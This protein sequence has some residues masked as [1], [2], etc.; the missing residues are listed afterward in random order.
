MSKRKFSYIIFAAL[1]ALMCVFSVVIVSACKKKPDTSGAEAGQYFCY[2]PENSEEYVVTLSKG[3]RFDYSVKGVQKGGKYTLEGDR[4]TLTYDASEGALV[5]KL[6]DNVISLTLD[7]AEL[8]FY[9][10]IDYTVTFE[11][12]GGSAVAPVTVV[13]GKT[14]S[15]PAEDPQKKDFVFVGWYADEGFGTAYA[16]GSAIVTGNLTLYARWAPKVEGQTEYEISFELGYAGAENPASVE[17]VGGKLYA[18]HTPVRE[19]YAF[20]GWWVSMYGDPEKLSYRVSETT[21]FFENTTLY[22]LWQP[23]A[24]STK[25]PRPVVDIGNDLVSWDGIM[26]AD[27]YLI[28]V[29]GPAGFKAV[30]EEIPTA[31]RQV[32]FSEAPA[33]DYVIRVTALAANPANNSDPAERF[34]VNKG[35]RKVTAFEVKDGV[36][37]F[38]E[39]EHADKYLITV[40]CGDERHNHTGYDNGNSTAFPFNNCPM[41]KEGGIRFTVTALAAGYARSVTEFTYGEDLYGMGALSFDSATQTLSW[42]E[43]TGV[44]NYKITVG[45]DNAEHD[46][47]VTLNNGTKT[48]FSLK[49]FAS[50]GAQIVVEVAPEVNGYQ[51]S[52]AVSYVYNK[53]NLATPSGIRIVGN[54]LSWNGVSGA[55]SYN[56]KINGAE[57]T[58][59]TN[60]LD[61]T[62]SRFSWEGDDFKLS[63]K[64]NGAESS[65]WSDELDIRYYAM[66]ASLEY[67][68]SV[69][70]W[71]HV[72]GADFYEVKVNDGEAVKITDGANFTKITLTQAGEN[73]LS[74]RFGEGGNAS[75][76]ASLTVFAYTLTFDSNGGGEVT[77][78]YRANGDELNL[79]VAEKT[80]YAFRLWYN[81]PNGPLGNGA[82]YAGELFHGK[83]DVT[84]YAYY[85]AQSYRATLYYHDG[86]GM[87][88]IEKR[89]VQ[90]N[91]SFSLPVPES[92]DEDKIFGGW[93]SEEG[94][95][96]VQFTDA[97]GA[98]ILGWPFPRDTSVHAFWRDLVLNYT[99]T[100][101]EGQE[102]YE[103]TKGQR[104]Y[105]QTEIVIP[106]TYMGKPVTIGPNAFYGCTSIVKITV[107]D[108]ILL[109]SAVTPFGGC[110]NLQEI[111]VVH[112]EG[113]NDV[114]YWAHEGVLYDDG[115]RDERGKA[116]SLVFAPLTL[117]GAYSIPADRGVT[118]INA[119]VFAG[120]KNLTAITIP[121]SVTRV[122]SQAFKGCVSLAS[123]VFA[124]PETGAAAQPLAVSDWAFEGCTSLKTITLPA[125]LDSIS[126]TRC[127]IND[128]TYNEYDFEEFDS[129]AFI[130]DTTGRYGNS[131]ITDAFK[132]CTSLAEIVV[133]GRNGKYSSYDGVL[134]NGTGTE[135]LY[136]PAGRTLA[137]DLT[138][139]GVSK[140]ANG[141]FYNSKAVY[142]T[143]IP[144]SVTEI[145]ELAFY[146]SNIKTLVFD[147]G[148]NTQGLKIGVCAFAGTGLTSVSFEVGSYVTEIGEMAFYNCT[149]L[150]KLELSKEIENIGYQAFYRCSGLKEITFADNA[151][152]GAA[153]TL[154]EAV[155]N[156]CTALER[157][158]LPLQAVNL[159][160]F[161]NCPALKSINISSASKN[162]AADESGAIFSYDKAV[163]FYFPAGVTEYVIPASVTAISEGVFRENDTLT[164][165]TIGKNVTAIGKNA[166][167]RC[168]A[169]SEVIFEAGGTDD[170]AIAENAFYQC[171]AIEA[172]NLPE[173]TLSVGDYAFYNVGALTS[174]TLG[175]R[176]ESIGK[177][178]FESTGAAQIVIPGTVTAISASA[179][180]HSPVETV[181]FGEGS[182]LREIGYRAFCESGLVSI[183]IPKT[184]TVIAPEAFYHNVS[185]TTVLFEDGGTENLT[186]G[187][188]DTGN[189]EEG[190][191]VYG[192]T[193]RDCTSLKSV[194]LPART[195]ELGYAVFMGCTS[196]KTVTFAKD[197]EESR[198]QFIPDRAFSNSGLTQITIPKSV[199]N[200]N[201]INV[202]PSGLEAF[203]A[204]A[205]S[206]GAFA[207]CVSLASVVFEAGNENEV[208]IDN[209]AFNGC[210]AL[211][212]VVLPA[213]IASYTD[214]NG[215]ELN[216]FYNNSSVFSGCTALESV[217]IDPAN[218]EY[219]AYLG[220]IYDKDYRYVIICPPGIRSA[221]I[222]DNVTV[223]NSSTFEACPNLTHISLP[224]TLANLANALKAPGRVIDIR[225][226]GSDDVMKL[227]NGVLCA[228][229]PSGNPGSIIYVPDA[230]TGEFV[231]P[232]TV[233]RI[234][235]LA[236]RESKLTQ[237]T[238]EDSENTALDDLYIE[239]NAFLLSEITVIRFPARLKGIGKNAFGSCAKLSEVTF[240]TNCR[241]AEI[242]N[243]AFYNCASLTSI[244][245]PAT[246][247]AIPE[248][249]SEYN[250]FGRCP[251]LTSVTFAA[252]SQLTS[253]GSYAFAGTALTGIEIP[254]SV[255]VIGAHAFDG[256]NSLARVGFASGSMPETI[257]AYAFYRCGALT[258]ITVPASVKVLAEGVFKDDTSLATVTFAP[259]SALEMIGANAFHNCSLLSGVVI[260]SKVTEI[261]NGAFAGCKAITY[262]AIPFGV[263]SLGAEVFSGCSALEVIDNI[264]NVTSYGES[265]FARTAITSFEL[266]Y[267]LEAVP[268][269]LFTGCRSLESVVIPD[270]VKSIGENA[271]NGCVSLA[272]VTLP[273]NAQFTEIPDYLFSGCR[274]LTQIT[275]PN[276]VKT[277]G[278]Y[279][280]SNTG[281]VE[282]NVPDSVVTIK[283]GAFSGCTSLKSV[284]GLKF[285]AQISSNRDSSPFDGCSKLSSI[286][287]PITPAYTTISSA[288]FS[289]CTGLTKIKIPSNVQRIE[290][291]AFYGCKSLASVEFEEGLL[292]IGANAFYQCE[293]LTNVELPTS[294]QSVGNGA[295]GFC[296]GLNT[297]SLN[298]GLLAIGHSAFSGCTRLTG[299]K[300]PETL[301]ELGSYA[302]KNC[303]SLTEEMEIPL[304]LT[305]IGYNPF[306]GSGVTGFKVSGD[307]TL[308]FVEEGA[309]VVLTEDGYTV[310]A[311]PA[312]I[313]G[314][315]T[316]KP[317]R[318]IGPHAFEDSLLSEI[319]LSENVKLIYDYDPYS[320]TDDR[321]KGYNFNNSKIERVVILG[322]NQSVTICAFGFA[323]MN[324]TDGVYFKGSAAEWLTNVSQDGNAN[325]RNAS[326]Y[327]YSETYAPD[328]WHYVEDKIRIWKEEDLKDVTYTF[329]PNNGETDIE[330]TATFLTTDKL[331]VPLRDGY[332]LEGWYDNEEMTGKPVTF[333]YFTGSNA[334]LYAKWLSEF[335]C[336]GTS[337]ARAFRVQLDG[338]YEKNV[339]GKD[340]WF[341]ISLMED[342]RLKI[343][344]ES[345]SDIM[346]F[347]YNSDN[348]VIDSTTGVFTVTK[349]FTADT[350][351][352]N[353]NVYMGAYDCTLRV[354]RLE[355]TPG[356]TKEKA[357]EVSLAEA[358]E[359][360]FDAGE[361]WFKLTLSE[362]A[363]FNFWAEGAPLSYEM[364]NLSDSVV[365]SGSL[366]K[367][368]LEIDRGTYYLRVYPG[369]TLGEFTLH[370]VPAPGSSMTGA[371]LAE[372]NIAYKVATSS[373]YWF[374]YVPQETV[375][376]TANVSSSGYSGSE[377]YVYDENGVQMS[378]AGG[379]Y[380][381][382]Y[383]AQ[384]VLVAGKTYYFKLSPYMGNTIT[385]T[386]T[387]E[388]TELPAGTTKDNAIE[389]DLT[390]G[391]TQTMSADFVPYW[392][393]FTVDS[394]TDIEISFTDTG[395]DD[396]TYVLFDANNNVIV[397]GT[398]YW[399]EDEFNLI[400]TME[401][402]TYYLLVNL[403]GSSNDDFTIHV[404]ALV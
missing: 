129:S 378:K 216:T 247:K 31:S 343:T 284:T 256:A 23:T 140:I 5:A 230:L 209:W 236:F 68:R 238:F 7:G 261:G 96:G 33:G 193:F 350:Y 255:K 237:I 294:L 391:L 158:T 325:L 301:Q 267:G 214:E 341:A 45:C 383:T 102:V 264:A 361:Y 246:V 393:T 137:F 118:A 375:K 34:Y 76:W 138:K 351:Y 104:I 50:C 67:S 326:V 51:S 63:L 257:G 286:E 178:A 101:F 352:V 347:L 160:G 55:T 324:L 242:G 293:K 71:R 37:S 215:N 312:N 240:D 338:V 308:M 226:D 360:H 197:G 60:S 20:K 87:D 404:N 289:G 300:L 275:V 269:S 319:V 323:G 221:E 14:L 381:F 181:T 163:L 372:L 58:V 117:S 398:F 89:S 126:L 192:Q 364:Y 42:D 146:R 303:L 342:T 202:H 287:L 366:P 345:P 161:V 280:F 270:S 190:L 128:Y 322:K 348:N 231:I 243:A 234:A 402:G 328:C 82:A 227:D 84:L 262:L 235:E 44:T 282:F 298:A 233:T 244:E 195:S 130:T 379:Y 65:L 127:V 285:V 208:T 174:L 396:I 330:V 281:I 367:A 180:A 59:Q 94:G 194:N 401:A 115:T 43:V 212:E 188:L 357:I 151:K 311:F 52:E 86:R 48:S 139:Y 125:R 373:A 290:S 64:A 56:V 123:V 260:P 179:F 332:I 152:A 70:S 394:E 376:L 245:I 13:N 105:N 10:N 346:Y 228:K 210:T 111:K 183:N 165:I 69:L 320:T 176:L 353:I 6:K 134:F 75:E 354:E 142:V 61:L 297:A 169:L 112:V 175:D 187:A 110:T 268:A 2:L 155:F 292:S 196:L 395:L 273:D 150:T 27:K 122:G 184:V 46:H 277:V 387:A 385:L 11:T 124:A 26:G 9:K 365:S 149:G 254:A 307:S 400:R 363:M 74:V 251:L 80:G 252:G 30:N 374:K 336:D 103:V 12:N 288:L 276:T 109:I 249:T 153:L 57:V 95:K 220:M 24:Q 222:H 16:F 173:R 219:K 368:N 207:W 119:S 39:V 41:R 148:T 4:L 144:S 334:T 77:E 291:Y 217:G 47:A 274:K 189:K 259:S 172:L 171:S 54:T 321:Y 133:D 205:V 335:E 92:P 199:G 250:L 355:E 397:N 145:G 21:V 223:L 164:R 19:G 62:D 81:T 107:P 100:T 66:S 384:S 147:A 279:A 198:L 309:L 248:A 258:E 1:A 362:D 229:D 49:E 271:F 85:E 317:N 331:P 356:S 349:N 22:A 314:S 38:S 266:P 359:G 310:L 327:Y 72:V 392:F 121:A 166:F 403:A 18:A 97:L 369:G 98:S 358:Y 204:A 114:R 106:E 382:N 306:V 28:E 278:Q 36:L 108:T 32:K 17:T 380:S 25:L 201:V 399:G 40:E 225:V 239:D 186:I 141:A 272:S 113:N 91:S 53:T 200:R 263:T 170:L 213:V 218:A 203:H 185:L 388:P 390:Q 305:S 78:A 265:C 302:F 253:V 206:E 35:L 135:L 386:F 299:L 3:N 211:K 241:L 159:P 333:P 296:F 120:V 15:E 371:V 73:T 143:E 389:V 116:T 131:V 182:V 29:S 329:R 88:G 224:A 191:Y 318:L 132:D 313:T 283:A 90:F 316:V 99:L 167:Y 162:L 93:Y 157:I 136:C 232:K 154:G 177:S 339:T 315:Y 83:E 295:F 340:S 377:L 370:I 344:V 337:K 8:R 304:T 168:T 79:P 156:H